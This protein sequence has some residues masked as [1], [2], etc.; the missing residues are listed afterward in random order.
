MPSADQIVA[1]LLEDGED[2][3]G[4]DPKSFAFQAA[5]EREA[6][7]KSDLDS[8]K[9]TPETALT[10]SNFYHRTAR[11]KSRGKTAGTPIWAR[12]TGRT[13]TW[14][15]R[16]NEFRIPVKYGMYDAFYIDHTNAHEWA[17]NEYAAANP[18]PEA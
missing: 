4:V 12:R 17:T 11:Y 10:V 18:A 2:D 16:P 3:L 13:K 7:V 9:I 5:D 8:G 14:K 6:Q 1:R 15:T